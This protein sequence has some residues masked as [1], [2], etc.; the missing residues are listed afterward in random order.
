VFAGKWEQVRGQAKGAPGA[1]RGARKQ[2][3]QEVARRFD[4]YRIEDAGRR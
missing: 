3:E 2:A 4:A 1:V